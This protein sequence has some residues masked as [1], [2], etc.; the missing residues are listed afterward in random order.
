MA[1]I[2]E[3]AAIG[4]QTADGPL[5]GTIVADD[6]AGLPRGPGDDGQALCAGIAQSVL[7]LLDPGSLV[8]YRGEA[9]NPVLVAAS[10]GVAEAGDEAVDAILQV[11]QIE[12]ATAVAEADILVIVT[13]G[14][15]V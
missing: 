1:I 11:I 7:L 13:T 12:R 15:D 5:L 9:R 3:R 2:G 6:E 14:K 4:G 8:S 10:H